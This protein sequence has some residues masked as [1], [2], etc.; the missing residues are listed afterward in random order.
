[1][2]LIPILAWNVAFRDLLPDP[3]AFTAY[4][5]DLPPIVLWGENIFRA[6][7]YGLPL[8]MPLRVYDNKQKAGLTIYLVGIFLYFLSWRPLVLYPES[9]WSISLI[10]YLATAVT[11]FF[12]LLGIN[13]IGNKLVIN[14]PFRRLYYS[15]VILGFTFFHIWHVVIVHGR[16]GS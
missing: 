11:P 7:A 1:L 12:F 16:L 3:F 14:I 15:I 8:L 13:L 2:L 6:I 4:W 9:A 10:G 5:E